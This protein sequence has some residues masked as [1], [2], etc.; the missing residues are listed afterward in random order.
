MKTTTTDTTARE[1]LVAMMKAE[2]CR[3]EN[4]HGWSERLWKQ[5]VRIKKLAVRRILADLAKGTE[6]QRATTQCA[7]IV[8]GLA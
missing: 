8:Y 5:G 4:Y 3:M 6:V 7:G 2:P 1:T